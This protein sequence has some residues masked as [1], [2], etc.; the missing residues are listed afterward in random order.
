MVSWRRSHLH[1][2]TRGVLLFLLL[3][4]LGFHGGRRSQFGNQ[5]FGGRAGA[6][7]TKICP[8]LLLAI[9]PRTDAYSALPYELFWPFVSEPGSPR[10]LRVREADEPFFFGRGRSPA[11]YHNW[12]RMLTNLCLLFLSCRVNRRGRC[13]GASF[14]LPCLGSVLIPVVRYLPMLSRAGN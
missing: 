12:E 8:A 5:R 13:W 6:G 10:R 14:G 4:R 7:G 11:R 2:P 1:C 9:V 3:A